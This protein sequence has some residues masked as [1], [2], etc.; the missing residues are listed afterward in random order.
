MVSGRAQGR[1]QL[2]ENPNPEFITL[3]LNIQL[4]LDEQVAMMQQ[5]TVNIHNL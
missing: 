5:Q 1:D 4:R 2:A 3:I